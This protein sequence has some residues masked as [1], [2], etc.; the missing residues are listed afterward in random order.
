MSKTFYIIDGHSQIYRAYYAPFRNISSPA[1]EPTRATYVFTTMLLNLLNTRK[2]DYLA[3]AMDSPVTSLDRRSLYAE[4]KAT[5]QARPEDL[6]PQEVRIE[7]IVR[8]MNIPIWR[9]GGLEADD[10]L[11][12]AA[13]KF[14]REG[15]EVVLVS[16]D[17]DLDQLL[18]PHVVM[19]DPMKDEVID[20]ATLLK[21]KG[22]TPQQALDVQTLCGDD[23]D[24]VPGVPGVGQKT[25][26]KL[27][28]QYGSLEGVLAN[29]DKLTPKLRE[30]LTAFLP[31]MPRTRQLVTLRRDVPL[32]TSLEECR[33]DGVNPEPLLPIFRELGFSRLVADMKDL[34]G[35]AVA[36]PVGPAPADRPVAIAKP[37]QGES[38]SAVGQAVQGAAA[39]A[40]AASPARSTRKK[41]TQSAGP[42]LF[43]GPEEPA[44]TPPASQVESAG[45]PV[46][47]LSTDELALANLAATERLEDELAQGNVDLAEVLAPPPAVA[48][49]EPVPT[50]AHDFD[51][52]LVDTPEAFE[53]LLEELKSVRRLSVDT[54]T[55]DVRP[56]W[57]TL[58][59]ISLAWCEGRAYYL[60]VRGPMGARVLDI[61][62]VRRGLGPILADP[63]VRKIGQNLKYDSIILAQAGMPLEGI[64]FDTFLAGYVLDAAMRHR[65]DSLAM[66]YLFHR[67]INI[68]ELIGMGAKAI[69]TDLV[70]TEAMAEYSA[71]DADVSLRLAG[72]LQKELAQQ[73]LSELLHEVEM[74]LLTV[75]ADMEQAGIKVDPQQLKRQEIDL[76]QQADI[77][78]ERIV[79]LAGVPF[80]PDSPKQLAEVLYTRLGLPIIKR[81]K[82]G[83]STDADVLAQLAGGHELP[84]LVLDYRQLT[85]LLGTYLRG[86]VE[87][88]HP[89]TGRVHASFNQAGTITGRLSSSDPNLQNIPIRSEMGRRIR[90]AF[91]AGDE[92]HVLLSADYSQI[93][94]RVLAHF[95]S[96]PTLLAAFEADQDIHRIVAA[97]VFGVRQDEVTP[98]QRARAKTVNFGIIYGQTA[99]G[100]AQV[101]RIGREEAQQFI[102]AYRK[103]FP[104]IDAFLAECVEVAR[105]QGY[106]ETI[107]KRR[108][109]IQD[110]NS[111]NGTLRSA[112]ERMAI[113]S[114]VQGSAADMMKLAMV[115]IHRRLRL[116]ARPSRM[117]LQIHDELVFETPMAALEEDRRIICHEME[118]A[119]TLRVPIKVDTGAGHNWMEA[120]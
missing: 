112:A 111:R 82:T 91:V 109:P 35:S 108:R 39:Q 61:D 110:I 52:R 24:N 106:V 63:E 21:T 87:C 2:P 42:G 15:I 4:Y 32:P 60:P 6:A 75:L 92:N 30:N 27:I 9:G 105:R 101:L 13:E 86:L 88:I 96:D 7:Q 49:A 11:A 8:T 119:M 94:L 113:N 26:V 12:S 95:C 34:G 58:V 40:R 68:H 64:E 57:A 77:L 97:E 41:S 47:D 50:T 98:D 104:Q 18:S 1:G 89:T 16:R 56:M 54:E 29:M 3:M 120:K 80:N 83:P 114:V 72:V 71:E 103:R 99:F 37:G 59:G 45:L 84:A 117:L 28:T 90:Q 81:N 85:K 79:S 23:S 116:E 73:G 115:N 10:Y 74:P 17:K 100:L 38:Q 31:L 65:L 20:P 67:C 78:R 66:R 48:G 69:T 70:P 51:Y 19:Y 46:G 25:A 14:A 53:H 33:W 118:N 5:R 22:Y 44:E 36:T 55:T 107:L 62:L 102:T 93:E 76:N 43:G